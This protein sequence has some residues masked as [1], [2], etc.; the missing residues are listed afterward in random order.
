MNVEALYD[1]FHS[2]TIKEPEWNI[3]QFG[4]YRHINNET[5]FPS[6]N[7]GF[8]QLIQLLLKEIV[9]R[10]EVP[11]SDRNPRFNSNSEGNSRNG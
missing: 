2:V 5:H 3:I 8:S 1:E 10:H 9:V 11:I 7:E 6:I 4:F